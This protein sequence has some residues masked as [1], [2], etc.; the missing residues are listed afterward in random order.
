MDFRRAD[1]GL[2]KELFSRVPRYRVLEG[3]GANEFWLNFKDYLLYAQEQWISTQRKLGKNS[4]R[5]QIDK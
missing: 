4:K 1:S 3:K 2:F 5:P